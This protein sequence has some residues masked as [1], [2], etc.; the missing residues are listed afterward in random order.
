MFWHLS[1]MWKV[2]LKRDSLSMHLTFQFCLHSLFN[3]F[4]LLTEDEFVPQVTQL[5]INTTMKTWCSNWLNIRNSWRALIVLMKTPCLM[6]HFNFIY[7]VS[8]R[9]TVVFRS[10]SQIQSL[11]SKQATVARKKKTFNRKEGGVKKRR[12]TDTYITHADISFWILFIFEGI[13]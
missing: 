3:S 5:V 11:T 9:I 4:L 7:T 2:L 1:W 6:I 8:V 13:D 12:G 10:F